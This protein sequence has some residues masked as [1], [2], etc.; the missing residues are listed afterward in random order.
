MTEAG[1]TNGV[2]ATIALFEQERTVTAEER[3]AINDAARQAWTN[4]NKK[5]LNVLARSFA[6][7]MSVAEMTS[8]LAFYESSVG[9]KM[10]T[11]QQDLLL[12]IGR[13][14]QAVE[15]EIIE[16]FEEL[17]CRRMPTLC[18]APPGLTT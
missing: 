18:K 11:V 5:I 6:T 16:E 14:Y 3:E 9:R 4:G 12:D 2:D 8:A 10:V 1:L 7:R 17:Y 13:A 15:P